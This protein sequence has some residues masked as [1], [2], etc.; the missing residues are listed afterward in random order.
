MKIIEEVLR[1][2]KDLY[3]LREEHVNTLKDLGFIDKNTI[4]YYI[5]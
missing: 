5:F 4:V 2:M 3:G 1:N